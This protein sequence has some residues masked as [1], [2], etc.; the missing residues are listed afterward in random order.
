MSAHALIAPSSLGQVVQCPAS[1]RMQ[2]GFPDSGGEEAAGGEASHWAAAEL[3]QGRLPEIDDFASNGVRLSREMLEG[4]D[5]YYA[6]VHHTLAPLGL[7]TTDGACEV[8][9]EC[10]DISPHC[11]GTPD[12]RVWHGRTLYVWDYKFGHKPIEVFGNYQLIAYA[13]GAIRQANA[14]DLETTV[15]MRIV[16][17]RANHWA[18]PVR[19]WR[20]RAS[21]LRSYCNLAA[22]AASEALAANSVARVGPEC[23]YCVA[24]HACSTLQNA[25]AAAADESGRPQPLEL[26]SAALGVELRYLHRAQ[27]HLGARVSGLETQALELARAGKPITHFR[28]EHGTGRLKWVKPVAEVVSMAKMMAVNV[29][30]EPEL[31]TP[32]QAKAAGLMPEL[33]DALSE[34]PRGG[35]TLVPDDGSKARLIFGRPT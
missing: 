25:A 4:A 33:V 30:K 34:R 8:A 14:N 21:D 6:D 9:V 12:Y 32:T 23:R 35:A 22:V 26:S 29:L 19:E 10:H 28:V 7:K 20:C 15:V 5:E 31:V 13:L 3:L 2:V 24:R 11:W 27:A 16:Q 17:P 1:L 18:G